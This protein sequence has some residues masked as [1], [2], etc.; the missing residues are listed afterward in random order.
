MKFTVWRPTGETKW[1][2]EEGRRHIGFETIKPVKVVE[3]ATLSEAFAKAR[4]L[5]DPSPILQPQ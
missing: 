4:N 3:A 2:D 1:T 5:R